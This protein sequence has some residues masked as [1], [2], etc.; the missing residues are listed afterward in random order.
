MRILKSF[1]DTGFLWRFGLSAPTTAVM[2]IFKPSLQ[3]QAWAQLQEKWIGSSWTN[4]L[5]TMSQ[6][7][8][9]AA[10]GSRCRSRSRARING[11]GISECWWNHFVTFQLGL[12]YCCLCTEIVWVGGNGIEYSFFFLAAWAWD[13]LYTEIKRMWTTPISCLHPCPLTS[14][15]QIFN[16]IKSYS[17]PQPHPY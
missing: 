14:A 3:V 7:N 6:G 15:L 10:G 9:L 16:Q 13:Y 8:D 1:R 2:L 12:F 11:T 4:W 5:L 17:P